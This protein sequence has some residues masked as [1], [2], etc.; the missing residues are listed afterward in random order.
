MNV[1]FGARLP[2]QDFTDKGNEVGQG[3]AHCR[4]Q[5]TSALL[6]LWHGP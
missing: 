1:L 2:A 3:W 4:S 5:A 6:G